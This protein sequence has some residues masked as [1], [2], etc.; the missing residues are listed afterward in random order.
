MLSIS[1]SLLILLLVLVGWQNLF[2]REFL[3]FLGKPFQEANFFM[4]SMPVLIKAGLH[5][6]W[7]RLTKE[8]TLYG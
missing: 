8:R 2:I 1:A 5:I 6:R 3:S 7:V 4:S